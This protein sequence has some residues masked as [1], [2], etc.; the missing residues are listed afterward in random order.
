M[1]ATD[2][3]QFA[4][5]CRMAHRQLQAH[6]RA[7]GAVSY[8]HLDVYK[9]QANPPSANVSD[10]SFSVSADGQTVYINGGIGKGFFDDLSRTLEANRFVQ[11]VVITSGGGYAGPGLDAAQLIRKRNLTVRVKSCLLYT[12][13]C[14]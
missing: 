10:A 6:Q 3:D 5:A 14:V 4:Q 13:R 1:R 7:I 2:R 12:S 8:T 9:R 11:R